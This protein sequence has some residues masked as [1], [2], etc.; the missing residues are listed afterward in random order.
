MLI[1]QSQIL[2]KTS[3]ASMAWGKRPSVTWL[4]GA[5]SS[6]L[7]PRTPRPLCKQASP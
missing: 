4:G 3:R 7:K 1:N 2:W 6:N 5:E